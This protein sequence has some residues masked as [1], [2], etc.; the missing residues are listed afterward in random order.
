M[1]YPKFVLKDKAEL[2][3]LLADKDNLY[4]VSCNKCFKEIETAEEPEAAEFIAL[5]T[6]QGKKIPGSKSDIDSQDKH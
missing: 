3:A 4:V 6:E 1:N 5:A 2:D